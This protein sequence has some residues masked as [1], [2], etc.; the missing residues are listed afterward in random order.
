MRN[1]RINERN[2]GHSRLDGG[3]KHRRTKNQ[4]QEEKARQEAWAKIEADPI[5]QKA[6]AS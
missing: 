5:L 6:Q 2:I 3:A 4:K 1:G